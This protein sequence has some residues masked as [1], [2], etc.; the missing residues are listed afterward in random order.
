M[1]DAD[2]RR[3]IR[4]LLALLIMLLLTGGI[5]LYRTGIISPEKI[6]RGAAQVWAQLP[7]SAR[8]KIARI[9]EF[10]QRSR[11]Q[12]ASNAPAE[13]VFTSTPTEPTEVQATEQIE[14]TDLPAQPSTPTPS[15]PEPTVEP[16]LA[17][18]PSPTTAPQRSK[19]TA[20]WILNTRWGDYVAISE[21]AGVHLQVV[22]DTNYFQG[23]LPITTTFKLAIDDPAGTWVQPVEV[24][25][26]GVADELLLVYVYRLNDGPS[27]K[28]I[29][30]FVVSQP[31]N[32]LVR[33]TYLK[34]KIAVDVACPN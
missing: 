11:T 12:D 8:E 22:D 7:E 23:S 19:I 33:F 26:H 3:G 18:Q 28:S 27:C 14:P 29:P 20:S 15:Q 2:L 16:S 31:Q 5:Y 34:E 10:F 6:Q 21:K 30:L 9:P 4:S 17:P 32:W 24:G 13:P 25:L 1:N